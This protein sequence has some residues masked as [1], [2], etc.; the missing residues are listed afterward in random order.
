MFGTRLLPMQPR[1]K[2][3]GCFFQFQAKDMY[4]WKKHLYKN[5]IFVRRLCWNFEGLVFGRYKYI[6]LEVCHLLFRRYLNHH[7]IKPK[8]FPLKA[9]LLVIVHPSWGLLL[10]LDFWGEETF[11]CVGY[12]MIIVSYLDSTYREHTIHIHRY[13]WYRLT[14]KH[15]FV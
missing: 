2:R 4:Y 10:N 14:K 9:H 5:I 3:G 11:D 7:I 8:C 15:T 6:R 13:A 1:S 12:I